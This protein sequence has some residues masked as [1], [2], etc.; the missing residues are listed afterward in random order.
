MH[1]RLCTAA[2]VI[3]LA[4]CGQ[5]APPAAVEAVAVPVP[6]PAAPQPAAPRPPAPVTQAPLPPPP[7]FVFPAD[8][9]GRALPAVVAPPAPALL[10]TERFGQ[11]PRERPVPDAVAAPEPT[12]RA[13]AAAPPVLPG[14]PAE[15]K[16][17]APPE[18][19]PVAL[20]V[21]ADPA[22]PRPKL[23]ESPG[24]TARA[25]DVN[26]PPALPVLARPVPDRA[27]LD[28]PT[29][30]PGNAAIVARPA[31]MPWAATGFLRLAL[32]DPFELAE[33]VRPNVPLPA[34]PGLSPVPV[35]P[36]R[37]K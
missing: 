22:P 8:A 23:P 3:A 2:A 24:V 36:Q 26:R 27:S 32:P 5:S 20:G 13:V 17:V 7:A 10:P 9:A 33:Q 15:L 28:D 18:R 35:N 21:G 31:G 14:K 30:E 4:G 37:V 6:E 1:T 12:G 11:T 25:P 19:V 34:E 29:A 16:P